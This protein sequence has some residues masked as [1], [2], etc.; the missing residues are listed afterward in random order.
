MDATPHTISYTLNGEELGT[1]FTIQPDELNDHA[2]FPHILS[3]NQAF[4]V[5]FGE[6]EPWGTP[7]PD[8]TYVGKVAVEDRVAGPKRPEKREDC[9]VIMMIG[10][11]GAGKTTW[12]FKYASEHKD[13]KFNILGTNQLLDKMKVMIIFPL[14]HGYQVLKKNQKLG[15]GSSPQA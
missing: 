6:Q 12:A 5:N 8:Y 2:L 11:P 14:I 10:L 1:A 9:E 7:L 13:K 4:H 3:K 15:H